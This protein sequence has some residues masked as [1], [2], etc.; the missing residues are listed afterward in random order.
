MN[1]WIIT[2]GGRTG[3]HWT[4]SVL[5]N[6]LSL[7]DSSIE[8]YYTIEPVN[9]EFIDKIPSLAY[10]WVVHTNQI[11]E[12][13]LFP[14]ETLKNCRLIVTQRRDLWSRAVSLMV[15]KHTDEWTRYDT[16]RIIEPFHINPRQFYSAIYESNTWDT[17]VKKTA[18][19]VGEFYTVW[20][21]DMI[22]NSNCLEQW[23][24]EQLNIENKYNV[25]DA[26]PSKTADYSLTRNPRNYQDL[27]T[28]WEELKN[29]YQVWVESN[30]T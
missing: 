25:D 12:L 1:G 19:R 29:V 20:Y 15:A 16:T 9:A 24:S 10:D 28:N 17:E 11:N 22:K 13:D 5:V 30:Q 2:G 8:R 6:I 14:A 7:Y 27:I 21:E 4:A 18:T 3:S 26:L 23:L